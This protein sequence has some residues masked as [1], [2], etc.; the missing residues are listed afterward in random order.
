M[1]YKKNDKPKHK[2][3][4]PKPKQYGDIDYQ[5]KRLGEGEMGKGDQL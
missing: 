1:E 5:R 2:I 3:N 4:E